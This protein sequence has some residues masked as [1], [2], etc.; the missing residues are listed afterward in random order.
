[1]I[2]MDEPITSFRGDYEFLSNFYRC[3]VPITFEEDDVTFEF[4]SAEAAFQA[5]KTN[6]VT[7]LIMLSQMTGSEAKKYGRKI[8][9]RD[10][11]NDIRLQVMTKV[12]L[13]KF[14][15][16]WELHDMLIAT[17]QREL[18][19]GNTWG[20]TFWGVCNGKGENHLGKILMEVR[21]AL[22]REKCLYQKF[23][24]KE[25]AHRE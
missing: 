8:K 17:G 22:I 1:V 4:G 9:L 11:W 15:T 13:I 25:E 20:D 19:E 7:D 16:N 23:L 2:D 3:R 14:I 12:V 5:H 21:S 10:D 18:I 6:N 24:Y